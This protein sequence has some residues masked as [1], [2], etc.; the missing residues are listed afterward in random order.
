M[1]EPYGEDV[2]SHSDPESCG[3]TREGGVEALTGAGTGWVLSREITNSG[4]PTLSVQTEGNTGGRVSASVRRTPRGLRP[5]ACDEAPRAGSRRA[6][7]L[8]MS[9]GPWGRKGKAEAERL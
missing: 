8:P 5:H 2:A 4:V 9:D 3:T 6:R 7:G 1:R